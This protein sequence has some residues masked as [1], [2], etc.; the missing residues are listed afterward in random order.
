MEKVGIVALLTVVAG[1]TA[2]ETALQAAPNQGNMLNIS[3]GVSIDRPS[4][5]SVVVPSG[6]AYGTK[7]SY[8]SA[9]NE[10][11]I[12]LPYGNTDGVYYSYKNINFYNPSADGNSTAGLDNTATNANARLVLK[13]H[14]DVPISQFSYSDS[15]VHW[16][17]GNAAG[18]HIAG[19]VSYSTDGNTWSVLNQIATTDDV[20]HIDAYGDPFANTT[21]TGLYTQ[22]L[23][24]AIYTTNLTNPSSVSDDGQGYTRFMGYRT[25]GAGNW[26][27]YY[28]YSNQWDLTVVTVPEAASL[29]LLGAGFLALNGRRQ[30]RR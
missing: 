13:L 17:L 10:T 11:H 16:I 21:V 22:D 24:I 8:N 26:G 25:S 15:N 12:W 27:E 1:L 20:T 19:G 28:F 6:F 9:T 3:T 30:A 5:D 7:Q 2:F 14:F 18:D 29:S 4:W 23:Y